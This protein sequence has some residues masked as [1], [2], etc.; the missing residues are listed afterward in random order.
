MAKTGLG[1]LVVM[2]L[3]IRTKVPGLKPGRDDGFLRAI[4]IRSTPSFVEEVKLVA[5]CPMVLRNVKSHLILCKAKFIIS[6]SLSS[7]LLLDDCW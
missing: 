6:F 2:V 3:V 1:D 7:C 5:P 4:K